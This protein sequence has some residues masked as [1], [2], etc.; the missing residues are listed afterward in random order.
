M[1]PI[2]DKSQEITKVR[3][4]SFLRQ[5]KCLYDVHLFLLGID[6]LENVPETD[7]NEYH[8]K[9]FLQMINGMPIP[10]GYSH[11]E[12]RYMPCA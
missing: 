1:T 4:N 6:Q 7:R 9:F 8:Y 12:F 5:N 10:R 2:D 11:I 3:A